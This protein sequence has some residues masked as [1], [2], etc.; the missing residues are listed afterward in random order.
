MKLQVAPQL[1]F[2]S[3]ELTVPLPVPDLVT[4]RLYCGRAENAAPTLAA[5]VPTVKLQAP[6]PE[7]APVQP[8]KV[9]E[10]GVSLSVTVVPLAR[11][12]EQV[13]VVAVQLRMAPA[14]LVL[15]TDPLPLTATVT[16]NVAT[17]KV[18]VTDSAALM[19]TTQVPVPEH[20]PPLQPVKVEAADAGVAVRVTA[21]PLT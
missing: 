6:V 18:A 4:V 14:G 5:A 7:Q 2:A 17:L 11:L 15:E 13:P 8:A 16:G 19:V 12:A 20:P 10:E 9:D 1:M 21:A 3:V